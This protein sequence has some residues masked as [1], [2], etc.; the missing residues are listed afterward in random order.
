MVRVAVA[1]MAV[2]KWQCGSGSV[3][4]AVAVWRCGW[5]AVDAGRVAVDAGCCG[6]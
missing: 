2:V 6:C 5:V 3:A 1:G 4:V